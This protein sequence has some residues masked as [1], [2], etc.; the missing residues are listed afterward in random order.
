MTRLPCHGSHPL[1]RRFV[2]CLLLAGASS[3]AF[4]Q[5]VLPPVD[6]F[7][8]GAGRYW[9]DHDL[10]TRW[11]ASDGS[12][13]TQV[14]F[15]RDLGFVDRQDALVWN[16]GGSVGEERRH[17][18]D[19]F[20]YDYDD[21]TARLLD[22]TLRIGD[23][24]Y[25]VDADLAGRMDLR[26]TGVSYTWFFHQDGRRAF[27]LGLGAMRY[28]VDI[29]L[30]ATATV[31]GSP[32]AYANSLSED[33]WAP[34]L[35][36]D[37]AQV[38]SPRWR[39]GASLAYTKKNGGNVTGDARDVQLRLEYFPWQHA[40]FSLRYNYNDVDLDFERTRFDGNLNLNNRGPQLL[41]M[42]RF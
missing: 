3:T 8:V 42:L 6:R 30:D 25:P 23:N 37:Y 21:D 41:A 20:G 10:D 39:W 16:I 27:G 33:E 40:G 14:N 38:L 9:A 26:V 15:Q 34:M 11:D 19:A 29:D 18:F 4:A 13:G 36:A 12:M 28:E 31:A 32:A 24:A 35:R 17:A 7:H 1:P 22:R 2:L 5:D